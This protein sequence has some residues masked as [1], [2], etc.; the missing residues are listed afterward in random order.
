MNRDVS[1]AVFIHRKELSRGFAARLPKFFLKLW[2]FYRLYVANDCI[3][4]TEKR[5][6]QFCGFLLYNTNRHEILV[7]CVE[8]SW[9]GYKDPDSGES[10]GVNLINRINESCFVIYDSNHVQSKRFYAKVG[11]K[12]DYLISEGVVR[13]VRASRFV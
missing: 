12:E 8:R 10:I 11:F 5:F 13:Y 2:Y 4:L 6:G 9:Q 1:E 7:I 3:L